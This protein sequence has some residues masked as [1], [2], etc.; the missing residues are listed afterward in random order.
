MITSRAK[1]RRLLSDRQR[2]DW[3]RL[4]KSENVGPMVFRT[5]LNRFGSA[6]A[7]LEAL[8]ELSARGGLKRAIRLCPI[9]EAEHDLEAAERIGAKF[10]AL[11][12]YDYPPLLKQVEDAPP[13]ICVKG[14]TELFGQP[15]IAVVG[16]RNASAIGRKMT[17]QLCIELGRQGFVVV[18]G[19]ARGIDTAAHEAALDTGTIAVTAGGVDV[20]YPPENAELHEKIAERGAVISEMVPGLR[21][22]A[23]HFP[24]RNRLI[25]G[26]CYGSIVIEAARRSGSLITARFALEQG[27]EVFAV[28]GSPLDPRSA[29]TNALIRDGATLV[30]KAADIIEVLASMIANPAAPPDFS[31]FKDGEQDETT[32]REPLE[33]AIPTLTTRER[34]ASLL[35]HA[36]TEIDDIIR[37]SDIDVGVIHM[38]LLELELAGRLARLDARR[39]TLL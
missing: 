35:S 31:H 4:I 28:P 22:Q 30:T 12:E 29:G 24:R 10:R 5:L 18:S 38:V 14:N 32:P 26:M 9:S 17:R 3:L 23:K 2:R 36:P 1:P 39:V 6:S 19:L 16:S 25:S 13:L 37:E 7:A 21:P 20:I 15:T 8:P 34:V 27:R 33:G 11:G